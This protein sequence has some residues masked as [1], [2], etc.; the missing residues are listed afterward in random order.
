MRD[1]G[2]RQLR[3]P[4]RD[5]TGIQVLAA[6]NA[7]ALS[8]GDRPGFKLLRSFIF[9]AAELGRSLKLFGLWSIS[10]R[11]FVWV[12]TDFSVGAFAPL[13]VLLSP[14]Y[15]SKC[16]TCTHLCSGFGWVGS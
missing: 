7:G 16:A 11:A 4:L 13:A 14:F 10:T 2:P 1:P 8:A 12:P 3:G 5:L 9:V 6:L 15:L